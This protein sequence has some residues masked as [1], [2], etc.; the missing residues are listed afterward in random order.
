MPRRSSAR[1]VGSGNSPP[2]HRRVLIAQNHSAPGMIAAR[3]SAANSKSGA[4]F[5]IA[6]A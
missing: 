1:L 4:P 6:S 3:Y 5:L 2:Q